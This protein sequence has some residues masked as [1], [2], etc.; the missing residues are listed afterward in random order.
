MSDEEVRLQNLALVMSAVCV[1]NT[2]IEDYH[3]AGKITDPEMEAFNRQVADKVYRGWIKV[4]SSHWRSS[5]SAGSE[6]QIPCRQP[7][8]SERPKV[9]EGSWPPKSSSQL[10]ARSQAKRATLKIIESDTGFLNPSDFS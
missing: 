8:E 2:I 4:W 6:R 3:G 5:G 10:I 9:S 1:R 7:P